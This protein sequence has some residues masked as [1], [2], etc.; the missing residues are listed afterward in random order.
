MELEPIEPEIALELYLADRENEVSASTLYSHKSRLGHFVRWC[1]AQELE[2]LNELTGRKLQRFRLWRRQEG[3]LAPV[4]EKTQMDTLRVFVRWLESIDAVHQDLSTKVLSPTLRPGEN[5]RDVMLDT[6]SATKIL[7]HLEKYQYASFDHVAIGLLWHTMMRVG[8][9]HSLD[10]EDYHSDEQYLEVRHRPKT[11]TPIKNQGD[12][13]RL[14]ALSEQMCELLD[15]WINHK[16]PDRVEDSGRR[17]LLTTLQGRASRSKIRV[18]AYTWSQ[19]CR[20]DG[21]CPYGREITE[22]PAIEHDHVSK[23]PSSVSPH[24][25]RRGSI[26]HFLNND[27]PSRVISDRANVSQAVLD[28]HYDRRTEREKMEQRREF[29]SNI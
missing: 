18:T 28:Q 26:T 17:P 19:P 29:L 8:A 1:D 10:V 25:V 3:D 24:A 23:C 20:I 13:E 15:D 12:G 14:V 2:N 4:T 6:E 27:M 9:A 7:A 22:C 16:R 11:G 5:T 21:E